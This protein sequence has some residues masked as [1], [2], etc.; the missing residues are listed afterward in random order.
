MKGSDYWEKLFSFNHSFV[1]KDVEAKEGSYKDL[2]PEALYTSF[3]DLETIFASLPDSGVWVDLGAG[4][5]QSAL[6]YGSLFPDRRAIAV[7]FIEA[8]F[9]AGKAVAGKL[10]LENVFFYQRDLL[11]D[12]IPEGDIYFLYFPTGPV[13][14]RIL[15]VLYERKK[16]FQLVAIESHGDLL[17]RLGKENW[18]KKMKEIPMKSQR[19]SPCAILYQSNS[20]LRSPKTFL[21]DQSFSQCYLEIQE[22]ETIWLGESFGLE[23]LKDDLFDLKTPPR[24]VDASQVKRVLQESELDPILSFVAKLRRLGEVKIMSKN[25]LYTG[26]IRKIY[27]SPCF[28]LEISS[29]E[30]VEWESIQTI[31]WGQFLCYD[32]SSHFFFLPPAHTRL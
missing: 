9:Q 8:R 27:Y 28:E 18:L 6:M 15:H 13:L 1:E 25:R 32:S 7:E 5:G 29:G 4:V 22:E 23:W 17:D 31:S 12:E 10:N 3:E 14:D 2:N 24:T 20:E 11:V 16:S 21:H 26:M 30:K 19:H